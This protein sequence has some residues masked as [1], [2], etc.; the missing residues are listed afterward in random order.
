MF[1]FTPIAIGRSRRTPAASPIALAIAASLYG[2]AAFAQTAQ[3]A[4]QT[5]TAG[6]QEVV[7]TARYRAE[8]LQQTPIAI[9]ALTSADLEQRQMT[10]VNDIGATVPNSYFRQPVSNYGPTE[11]IGL[12][13]IT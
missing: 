8:N 12:R 2:A 4:A 1:E 6:L 10:N 7:V 11:T 9:T 13:G 5:E 3:Q